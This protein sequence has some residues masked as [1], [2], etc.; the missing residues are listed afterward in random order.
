MSSKI[1]TR[2]LVVA[3]ILVALLI[4]G[5]A[6]FYASSD[7]DGLTKVSEDKGFASSEKEHGA[8]AGPFAGYETKGVDD[9][10]LSGGMAGVVGSV[11][12]L[13]VAGGLV[14]LVRRR[15]PAD[16]AR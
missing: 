14:L 16:A 1:S 7:P 13:V 9:A 2:A 6:S 12:V 4:A 10:R 8:A 5:V 15:R 11:V 3:G